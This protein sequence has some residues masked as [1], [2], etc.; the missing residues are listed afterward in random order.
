VVTVHRAHPPRLAVLGET[1]LS[2]LK[3]LNE[4]KDLGLVVERFQGRQDSSPA[5]N[6]NGFAK[7]SS[8]RA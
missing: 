4:V 7:R 3:I 6:D 1:I 8:D 5:Q 2:K